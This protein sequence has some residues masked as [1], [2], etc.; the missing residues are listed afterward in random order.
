MLP[1]PDEQASK[2]PNM[3][4]IQMKRADRRPANSRQPDQ[5]EA[6]GGPLEVI[7]PFIAA[8]VENGHLVIGQR[9]NDGQTVRFVRIAPGAGEREIRPFPRCR[10]GSR[11]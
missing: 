5:F 11:G 9:I 7:G 10:L 8:W 1:L 3:L 4:S 6:I 2:V